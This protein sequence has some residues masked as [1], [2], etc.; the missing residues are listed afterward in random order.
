MGGDEA[1]SCIVG[2]I[3]VAE[4]ESRAT[5]LPRLSSIATT[6]FTT[7]VWG[8][9]TELSRPL[10]LVPGNR[11]TMAVARLATLPTPAS[12]ISIICFKHFCR[13]VPCGV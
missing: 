5:T 1:V 13:Y 2:E 7:S 4:V 3:E 10:P 8:E 9:A 11:H 12:M 6:I